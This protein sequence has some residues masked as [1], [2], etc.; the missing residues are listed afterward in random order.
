MCYKD[1]PELPL[2]IMTK[3]CI[4]HGRYVIVYNEILSN[5]INPAEY[6]NGTVYLRVCEATVRGT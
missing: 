3:T 6:K 5:V 4:A 1:G 2:L